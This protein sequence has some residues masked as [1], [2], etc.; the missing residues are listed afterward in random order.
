MGKRGRRDKV[1]NIKNGRRGLRGHCEFLS[2]LI[3]LKVEH[4][5]LHQLHKFKLN[6]R[7]AA[8]YPTYQTTPPVRK[9]GKEASKLDQLTRKLQFKIH[10]KHHE[11]GQLYT[12]PT[13]GHQMH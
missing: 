1:R 9:E 4:C 13:F 8:T 6:E 12:R 5:F 10:K 2:I 3:S 11:L 7:L